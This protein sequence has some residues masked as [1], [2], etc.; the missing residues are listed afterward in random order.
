MIIGEILDQNKDY[1]EQVSI[2]QFAKMHLFLLILSAIA[3]MMSIV[4]N[5]HDSRTKGVLNSVVNEEDERFSTSS[6][7]SVGVPT[8]EEA[9]ALT[10]EELTKSNKKV[11]NPL[12]ETFR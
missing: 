10:H 7:S 8:L 9:D 2:Q 6:G 12:L 11:S 5:I 1:L 3:V 4:L